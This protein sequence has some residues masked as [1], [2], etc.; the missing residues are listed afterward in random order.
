MVNW[1]GPQGCAG[2]L[3]PA[4]SYRFHRR[5]R[6]ISELYPIPESVVAT[7]AEGVITQKIPGINSEDRLS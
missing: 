6:R 7:S 5:T 2:I 3:V 4:G 1:Q